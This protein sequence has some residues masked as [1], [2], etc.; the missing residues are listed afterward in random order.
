MSTQSVLSLNQRV[1]LRRRCTGEHPLHLRRELAGSDAALVPPAET[2]AQ[3]VLEA[4][5][6]LAAGAAVDWVHQQ[7]GSTAERIQVFT[8]VRP[9]PHFIGLCIA[10]EALNAFLAEA[11]PRQHDGELYGAAGTRVR[12]ERDHLVLQVLGTNPP[13]QARV[14]GVGARRWGEAVEFI[15]E[16]QHPEVNFWKDHR[17]DVHPV[18]ETALRRRSLRPDDLMSAVLRRYLLWQGAD[19]CDSTVTGDDLHV[20]WR[21]GPDRFETASVLTHSACGIPG[22]KIIPEELSIGQQLHLTYPPRAVQ[23]VRRRREAPEDIRAS[24]TG[25][26][27]RSAALGLG[28]FGLGLDSCSAPQRELR[29]LLALHLFNAGTLGAPPARRCLDALTCYDSSCRPVTTNW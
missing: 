10:D 24:F 2:R 16:H 25:E 14:Y 4:G 7:R 15:S 20:R 28:G 13:A 18:E 23:A 3:R 21:K 26:T 22:V 27:V 5:L 6:L 9:Y 17:R 1:E 12:V 19:W 29:A 11:L 8:T